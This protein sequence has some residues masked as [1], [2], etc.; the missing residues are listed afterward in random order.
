MDA[1]TGRLV[2]KL[3]L[4]HL[5]LLA[6]LAEADTMR[7]ASAQ[8]HL[9]QPAISK[10]LGEIE[11]CFGARL[12]ERSHQG[13]QPNALGAGA[14]FHARAVL[15]QLTRATEDVGAMQQGAQAVLRVGA[16]S[17]TATVPS[18]I[19]RLRARMPGAV[20]QIRE[21]RVQELIQRLLT[22]EL[23]CVYGAVTPELLTADITPLLEPV[24]MLQD[25]LCVLASTPPRGT[26]R[27]RSRLRWRDLGNAPWLLPPK[28]T[29]VRQA[30]MTAF[31]NDGAT[32]PVP[33]IEAISSVTIGALMRQD[34]SL[35]CAVRQE[36][37]R[38][39]I[40]RGGV[41]RLDIVP[42]VPLP[43]FGLFFRRDGMERPAVLL[44]FAEAVRAAAAPRR[45][46]GRKA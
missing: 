38:D 9:S 15:N 33:V 8:L 43:S 22:G 37:A 25:E 27:A 14:V 44:A 12:F 5:E 19:A 10:M 34:A 20:V 30:F 11:T 7:S 1:T 2:R 21:G 26:S 46:R 31:L 45:A 16:P 4:R 28:D 3:R 24:A 40:A 6:V 29:L 17:V 39:E 13:I 42:K 32:P 41:H 35:L 36:H 23:D 18:A